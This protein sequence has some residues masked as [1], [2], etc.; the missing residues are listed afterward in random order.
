V[1]VTG[2]RWRQRL[3]VLAVACGCFATGGRASANDASPALAAYVSRADES[4]GWREIGAGRIGD[5]E[6]VELVLTSQTWRGI[7]WKHQLFVMLPPQLRKK[8]RQA[9]LFIGGGRWKAQYESMPTQLDGSLEARMFAQLAGTLRAPVAVLRQVPHQPLFER[10]EDALIAYSFDRYLSTGEPDWPLLLPMVKSAVR[11]MDAVQQV[12][13]QRWSI[14]I[15]NFTVAGASKR[16]WTS[17]LTAAVDRRVVAVA[18]MVIDVLNI[19]QQID[20]QVATWGSLSE[21]IRDYS[22]LDIPARLR[23]EARG[24]ELLSMVDPYAYRSQL[25]QSKLILLATNDP[26]WPLDALRLYWP[27]LHDPKR[28]LY[29]PNQGH[30]VRDLDRLIGSIAALHRYAARNEPLPAPAWTF[31]PEPRRLALHVQSDRKPERVRLWSAT[32]PTRDFRAAHWSSQSCRRQRGAWLCS[33]ARDVTGFTAAF[34]ELTFKDQR[35]PEF[36]LSTTV[37]IAPPPG[38]PAPANC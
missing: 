17:W 21:Q 23:S 24:A 16:G 4:Q 14:P 27:G 18:P 22:D 34:A 31:A 33:A 38:N 5:C 19:P 25:T 3:L 6:Y 35:E 32:S 12:V 7:A 36:S 11:A 28:V 15:D 26:Y 9:L 37:C 20:N 8:S 30:G 10:R 13:R 1:N 29:I 2:R